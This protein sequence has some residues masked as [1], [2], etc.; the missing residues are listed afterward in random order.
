M[1]LSTDMPPVATHTSWIPRRRSNRL[2][3]RRQLERDTPA[4]RRLTGNPSLAAHRSCNP[5]ICQDAF[6]AMVLQEKPEWTDAVSCCVLK[7]HISYLP[8]A[9]RAEQ[10]IPAS[11]SGN[12]PTPRPSSRIKVHDQ[13]TSFKKTFSYDPHQP[14]SSYEC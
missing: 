13:R 8:I 1:L 2:Q 3:Q 11:L 12:S 10:W 9:E 6:Y 7:I 4:H 5:E 14:S